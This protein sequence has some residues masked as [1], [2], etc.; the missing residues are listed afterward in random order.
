MEIEN[1]PGACLCKYSNKTWKSYTDKKY[2][3]WTQELGL[4]VFIG[5]SWSK[6]KYSIVGL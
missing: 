2:I 1:K 3:Q 4:K 5:Q 6:T